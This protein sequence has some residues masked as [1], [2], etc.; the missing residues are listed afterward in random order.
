MQG[1]ARREMCN[2]INAQVLQ[3]LFKPVGRSGSSAEAQGQ[4]AAYVGGPDSAA[5]AAAG[6]R[7]RWRKVTGSRLELCAP[8]QLADGVPVP[9]NSIVVYCVS[10][11]MG[12]G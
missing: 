7:R 6:R 9:L 2:T 8:G 10:R 4:I 12:H 5:Q 11:P 1:R 3:Q